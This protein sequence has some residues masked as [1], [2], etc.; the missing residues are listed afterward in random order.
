MLD[1]GDKVPTGLPLALSSG[2][3]ITLTTRFLWMCQG[4]YRHA[5]GYTPDWPAMESF[6]GR[7]IHPQ[8]WPEDLDCSGKHV[9]V[10][11]S[12]ATAAMAVPGAVT[13]IPSGAAASCVRFPPARSTSKA[14]SS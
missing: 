8:Q 6:Q 9:V 11:G 2:E 3:T 1:T 7:I 12:G 4:Y 14:R 5:K 13:M 10:V